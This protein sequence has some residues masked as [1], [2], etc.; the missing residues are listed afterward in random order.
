MDSRDAQEATVVHGRFLFSATL[1]EPPRSSIACEGD[2][3]MGATLRILRSLV[4]AKCVT[5][6]A[7]REE[8][9]R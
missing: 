7:K 9:K 3:I 2:V 1:F 5:Q 4:N 6:C 8:W